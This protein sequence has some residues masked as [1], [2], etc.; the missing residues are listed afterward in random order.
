MMFVMFF[1][2]LN[3]FIMKERKKNYLTRC[4][5]F[6]FLMLPFQ[7]GCD[8]TEDELQLLQ[9]EEQVVGNEQGM[10]LTAPPL[11]EIDPYGNPIDISQVVTDNENHSKGKTKIGLSIE[12]IE[13]RD[14]F[15]I[16][17]TNALDSWDTK[18][19]HEIHP[20][21]SGQSG[22][23]SYMHKIK[24]SGVG[25][26]STGWVGGKSTIPE[27]SRHSWNVSFREG[28]V[29]ETYGYTFRD[30]I[31]RE[32][33]GPTIIVGAPN[34]DE[35]DYWNLFEDALVDWLITGAI[36]RK[37]GFCPPL[38]LVDDFLTIIGPPG[39]LI[40]VVNQDGNPLHATV[41]CTVLD[42]DAYETEMGLV[43]YQA[44]GPNVKVTCNEPD[45]P[46]LWDDNLDGQE[47]IF[48]FDYNIY[49]EDNW[50]YDNWGMPT[51]TVVFN[52]NGTAT[53]YYPEPSFTDSRDGKVYKMVTIGTQTW[54]AE[55]LNYETAT[56]WCYDNNPVNGEIYGR[57]YTWGEAL[58]IAPPG[59]HLPT[60]AEWQVLSDCLGGSFAV[61]GKLKEAGTVHWNSPN[62]GATNESRFTA[63]PGGYGDSLVNFDFY[64][65]NRGSWWSSEESTGPMENMA[66]C[67]NLS[68]DNNIFRGK[69]E[70]IANKAFGLSVRCVKD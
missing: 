26:V 40:N 39:Y 69:G 58:T 37:V 5:L 19:Y 27:T 65:R 21:F 35:V 4:V 29:I 41:W 67:R 22:K 54:M 46:G 8:K 52:T 62:T 13:I 49:S 24:V 9:T 36:S 1:S 38:E 6:I 3:L 34:E 50:D 55:N 14:G 70:S 57:L 23:I 31:L 33:Q 18:I 20:Y 47:I 11:P 64:I 16:G 43:H 56:S 28:D 2:N 66:F 61:A 15:L 30:R 10:A 45:G 42:V 68:Y 7:F 17:E 63:L 48:D 44:V 53:V 25:W 60:D 12:K 59:W 32:K 51:F